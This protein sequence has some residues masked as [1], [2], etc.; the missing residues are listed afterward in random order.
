M[1]SLNNQTTLSN[2][3]GVLI[4]GTSVHTNDPHMNAAEQAQAE[5]K[6]SLTAL[7]YFISTYKEF[8]IEFYTNIN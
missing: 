1:R 5:E 2:G 3:Y 4:H 7:N 8:K 6:R